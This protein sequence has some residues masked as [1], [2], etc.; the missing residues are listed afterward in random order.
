LAL[1]RGLFPLL[2]AHPAYWWL[3]R[4]MRQDQEF[5]ADA[6]AA[7]LIGPADYAAPLVVWARDLAGGRRIVV[8]N[9]VGIWERPSGFALRISTIL[10]Q[11]DRITLRCSG[12]VRTAVVAC[13]AA[14][15]LIAASVSVR[16][17]NA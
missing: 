15:S 9:A 2:W 5:L 17:P 6:A 3:R 10:N 13:L 1:D 16:P 11:A 8:S 12:R 7:S 14:L 4:R